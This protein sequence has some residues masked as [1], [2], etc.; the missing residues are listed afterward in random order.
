[1]NN[2]HHQVRLIILAIVFFQ[3]PNSSWAQL[4]IIKA[5]DPAELRQFFKYTKDRIPFIAAHR[6]GATDGFPENCIETFEN[7]LLHVPAIMEVDPRLTKDSVIILMHDATLE[8]TTNGFGNVADYT[9]DELKSLKLKDPKGIVTPYRIPTLDEAL[10]WAKGKTILILDKKTVPIEITEKK[11]REHKA[12]AYTVVI[13]YNY[14]EAKKYHELNKDIMIEVFIANRDHVEE[15]D[16]IGVPWEHILVSI[17][18]ARPEDKGLYDLIHQK[19]AMCM[20]G[21]YRVHDKEY[22]SGNKKIYE[23][24]IMEGGDIL[25]TDLAIEA[26]RAI[27]HLVPRKTSKSK[28]FSQ[29]KQ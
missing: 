8:R 6:G 5:K 12:E 2:L 28:Y 15:F 19:G 9:W 7:T 22:L 26:G 29:Q 27:R 3:G 23:E 24:I 14:Q 1:M 13:A 25:Q 4:N 18:R 17:S 16:K 21:T 10:Q 20:V 11:V